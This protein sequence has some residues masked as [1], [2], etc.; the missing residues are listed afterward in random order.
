VLLV[1]QELPGLV[2]HL[3]L[4]EQQAFKEQ[5]VLVLPVSMEHLGL[6]GLLG[7]LVLKDQQVQQ[8]FKEPVVL[9]LLE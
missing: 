7:L 5:V 1:L 8:E 4:V 2:V 6:L 9:A 3:G